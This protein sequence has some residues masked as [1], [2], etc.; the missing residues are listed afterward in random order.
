MRYDYRSGISVMSDAGG[1]DQLNLP[2]AW[3]A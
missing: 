3:V 2:A 1:A